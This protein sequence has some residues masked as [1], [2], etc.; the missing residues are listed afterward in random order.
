MWRTFKA[1]LCFGGLFMW[2]YFIFLNQNNKPIKWYSR[3]SLLLELVTWL[4]VF[5]YGYPAVPPHLSLGFPHQL[6]YGH[7]YLCFRLGCSW[8]SDSLYGAKLE[9]MVRGSLTSH[10]EAERA[11]TGLAQSWVLFMRWRLCQWLHLSKVN[12]VNPCF[13]FQ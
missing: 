4:L 10:H 3:W 5:L 9:M 11:T 12:C 7:C 13:S 1:K 6:K 8:G 2:L